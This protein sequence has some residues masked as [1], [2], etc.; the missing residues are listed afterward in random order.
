MA[1]FFGKTRGDILIYEVI[2]IGIFTMVMLPVLGNAASQLKLIVYSIKREQALQIAEAGLNYYQWRLAHFPAD[3]KDGTGAPGPYIHDYKDA[4]TQVVIGRYSLQITPP[5]VGSTVVTIS[6][7]GYTLANPNQKRTI[8]ARYGIPSLAKY[9][10]LTNDAV[11]I[12]SGESVS[13]QLHANNGIRFDGTGNAPITSAKQTY[14]CFAW[15]GSPCPQN[16]PGIWGS[17]AQSTRSFWRFPV[18][19]V[20]FSTLTSDLA[21]LKTL[22]QDNGIYLPPSNGQGYSL[23][24]YG[25]NTVRIYKVDSLRSHQTGWDVNGAAHNEDLDYSIRTELAVCAP[26]PCQ[27]PANGVIFSED[28]TWV[29]GTVSGRVMVAAARLPYNANT[30]PSILIPNNILYTAKDGSVSLGLLG[31][32]DVLVTYYAPSALEIDAALIAQNGSVQRYYFP[33]DIKAQI[34]TYGTLMSFGV[35]T[36]SWVNSSGT[37]VSGYQQTNTIYDSNLLYAPPPDFPLTSEGYRQISWV[38]N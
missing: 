2:I 27:L 11:W 29:E 19:T 12:G 20:D 32:K 26:S 1:K 6:S 33:G 34:T 28:R 17:A 13:G 24:F 31:Q 4:D 15:Q 38:S 23:E 25:D 16:K 36:W 22:A 9:A 18:P 3:Y 21:N 10:F 30:A 37:I 14:D 8:T 35:W 7:T 5:A